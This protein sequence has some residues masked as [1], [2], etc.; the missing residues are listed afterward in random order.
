MRL[1]WVCPISSRTGVGAYAQSVLRALV[2]RPGLDITVLHPPCP[3]Q[4]RL[5]MPCPT[6]PLSD[7]LVHSDLPA[8]FD[9]MLYHLGNNDRHHGMILRALMAH[10][11]PVVLHDHVYQH[12]LAGLHHDGTAPAPGFGALIHAVAGASGFDYLAAGG[13]LKG[14]EP[15]SYVPWESDWAARV[16]LSDVLARLA[17]GVITHSDFAARAIGAAYPG[18]S[19]TLFM[20]RPDMP[21][22]PPARLPGPGARLRLAATGH[23][24]PTK[25]LEILIGA[26][27]A[28]PDLATR[29]SVTIAG[30]AGDAAYVQNL[31]KRI[32]AQDL[33]GTI[34]I[35]RS[36]NAA[37]FAAA[38]EEADLFFNL[39]RPNTEGASLS[40]AEQLASGRPA[41]VQATGC[42]A[43][44]PAKC[45]W[46]LP[47]SDTAEALAATLRQIARDPAE[48]ARR[49]AAAARYMAPRDAAS[50]A[51]KLATF[52]CAGQTRMARRAGAIRRRSTAPDPQDRDWH[53]SYAQVRGLMAA[54]LNRRGLLPPDLWAYPDTDVGRYVALN[55]LETHVSDPA[56]LGRALRQGGA[57]AS[58]ARLGLMRQL[59]ARAEDRQADVLHPISDL[60]LPCADPAL[61]EALL[62]LPADRALPMG[63][64][65]LGQRTAPAA[66]TRLRD[67]AARGGV[68]PTLLTYLDG[69]GDPLLDRP[70]MAAVRQHLMATGSALLEALPPLG[71]GADLVELARM[72]ARRA[73]RLTGFHAPEPAGIWTAQPHATIHALPDPAAT[74]TGIFGTAALLEPAL[75]ARDHKVTLEA[76]EET[77]GRRASWQDI[78]PRGSAPELSFALPLPGFTG[79]LRLELGLPACHAPRALGASADPRPLGLLLRSLRF[80][81]AP[82]QLTAAE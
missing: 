51:D 30:H 27:A 18:S 23:I 74:V 24:G 13:V 3:E 56:R 65:A 52:L 50:Y 31:Q 66:L 6:L 63:L 61:W 2:R 48:I 14:G 37:G 4:E 10:P 33:T 72:P 28:A 70:E 22:D 38:I 53:A 17:T 59:L 69:R 20:P 1:A 12:M 77:T 46:H 57:I 5:E 7:A 75:Q 71:P 79:P 58:A 82:A 60:A 76:V 19:L 8:L 29:F 35:L 78:R 9:L 32:E 43:E 40:L 45:G 49:G 80:D 26:F 73:L 55:L 41:I 39:R 54:I 21:A 81:T 47:E 36:P 25:G 42:F 67:L 64:H 44:M 62:C 68:G 15:V 16:P 34:R 11:G